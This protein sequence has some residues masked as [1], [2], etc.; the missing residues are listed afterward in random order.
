MSWRGWRKAEQQLFQSR[1][2]MLRQY[3]HLDRA[4]GFFNARPRTFAAK[5][6]V[7]DV[8]VRPAYVGQSPAA[9]KAA[10]PLFSKG[11][12]ALLLLFKTA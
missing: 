3:A 11:T 12:L 1:E 6:K 7:V 5:N 9:E 2:W 10:A 4:L 8:A